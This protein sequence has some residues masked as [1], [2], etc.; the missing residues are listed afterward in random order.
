MVVPS[1]SVSYILSV[2]YIL[3]N[4]GACACHVYSIQCLSNIKSIVSIIFHAIYGAMHFQLTISL[5]TIV[6]VGV[7]YLLIIIK[8]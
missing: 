7:L 2:I 6:S 3:V 1:Y 8:S 5:V 4:L